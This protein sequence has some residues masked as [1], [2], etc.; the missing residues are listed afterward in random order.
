[1]SYSSLALK[2]PM[3]KGSPTWTTG[4]NGKLNA[5]LDF[6][7]HKY[8]ADHRSNIEKQQCYRFDIPHQVAKEPVLMY[9]DDGL[10]S[11]SS[12]KV[13]LHEGMVS[14]EVVEVM[15]VVA[16]VFGFHLDVQEGLRLRIGYWFGCCRF[17]TG[18]N[19]YGTTKK[20]VCF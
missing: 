15:M 13:L 2:L 18:A 4:K 20:E 14:P 9:I 3:S 16:M 1:M 7:Q 8:R 5:I 17:E 12:Y 11:L 19:D 6:Q 10:S